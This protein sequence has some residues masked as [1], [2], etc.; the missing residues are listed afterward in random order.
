MVHL[1][2][3]HDSRCRQWGWL[4]TRSQHPGILLLEPVGCT[5]TGGRQLTGGCGSG[6]LLD[7]AG[8]GALLGRGDPEVQAQGTHLLF[9]E[10]GRSLCSEAQGALGQGGNLTVT[11]RASYLPNSFSCSPVFLIHKL[12]CTKDSPLKCLMDACALPF[13][14]ISVT[15]GSCHGFSANS[16]LLPSFWDTLFLP[17]HGPPCPVP[18]LLPFPSHLSGDV[19]RFYP[20]PPSCSECPTKGNPITPR[21]FPTCASHPPLGS[22][23]RPCEPTACWVP[24]R[25]CPQSLRCD[26][27]AFPGTLFTK[28]GPPPLPTTTEHLQ[29]PL[30]PPKTWES[31]WPHLF[32]I[33]HIQPWVPLSLTPKGVFSLQAQTSS[34]VCAHAIVQDL[35]IFGLDE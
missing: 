18:I 30:G 26:V 6:V 31:P 35:T 3:P 16:L 10:L 14:A 7:T 8:H 29:Q 33:P 23:P 9:Y 20:L 34:H 12:T 5:K 17:F 4:R 19:P 1:R 32:L 21:N 24:P 25:R 28:S 13:S 27:S 2:A 15:L 11:K 22:G